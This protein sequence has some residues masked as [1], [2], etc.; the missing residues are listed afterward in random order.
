[1]EHTTI[2]VGGNDVEIKEQT[3]LVANCWGQI[4]HNDQPSHHMLFVHFFDGYK[5]TCAQQGRGW[6][7]RALLELYDSGEAM[8]P[9]DEDNGEMSAWFVLAAIGLYLRSPGSLDAEYQFASP[10]F[11]RVELNIGESDDGGLNSKRLL[12][13]EARNSGKDHTQIARVLWNNEPLPS[14][15]NGISYELLRQGGTLTFEMI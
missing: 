6:V 3:E 4:A 1:M 12:V 9:G 7:K 10:L 14:S 15:S 13:V 2:H 8:Y 5:G 11:G